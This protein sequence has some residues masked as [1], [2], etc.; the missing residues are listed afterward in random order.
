MDYSS[1]RGAIFTESNSGYVN[2]FSV[3]WL[4]C[5]KLQKVEKWD[6]D[7]SIFVFSK[8]QKIIY[9]EWRH[10]TEKLITIISHMGP[11]RQDFDEYNLL[12][13]NA[14]YSSE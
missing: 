11:T 10:H 5:F 8:L 1:G 13:A 4:K 9:S 3:Q 6:G 12:Q 14:L 2:S 7:V